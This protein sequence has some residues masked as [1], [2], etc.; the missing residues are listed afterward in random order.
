MRRIADYRIRQLTNQSTNKPSSMTTSTIP[1]TESPFAL[2]PSSLATVETLSYAVILAAAL[3]VRML[4]LGALPLTPD[5]AGAAWFAWL[6]ATMHTAPDVSPPVSALLYTLHRLTF[7]LFDGGDAAARLFPALAGAGM[8]ALPWWLRGRMGRVPALLAALLLAVDPW[9]ITASRHADSTILSLGLGLL[10]LVGLAR[11]A[12]GADWPPLM[13]VA[14]GLFLIS[15]PGTWAF[16]PLLLLFGAL[17]LFRKGVDLSPLWDRQRLVVLAASALLGG[18][19]WLLHPSGLAAVGDSLG[20]WLGHFSDQGYPLAWAGLRLVRDQV[21]LLILGLA[22]LVLLLRDA[23][24]TWG[25]FLAGWLIWALILLFLPGRTPADLPLLSLPLLLAAPR[26]LA[27]PW[28]TEWTPADRQEGLL[29]GGILIAILVTGLFWIIQYA[30]T[31]DTGV[32]LNA[33]LSGVLALFLIGFF[34][35]WANWPLAGRVTVLLST[36]LLLMAGVA[37]GWQVSVR[38]DPPGYLGY[39]R[40]VPD[41]DT[42]QLAEDIRTLSAQRAGD[43]WSIPVQVQVDAAPDP[44]LG[45]Y[46]RNVRDLRWVNAPQVTQ[47]FDRS[48]LV[49]TP[50]DSVSPLPEGYIGSDYRIRQS[51]LPSDLPDARA[52]LR[53]FLY[54]QPPADRNGESVV[55]WTSLMR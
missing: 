46:L 24:R 38:T 26:L 2:R 52:R 45:W 7:A 55:L 40:T 12:D 32:G 31:G 47:A 36:G 18:T 15:G 22:G 16:L 50:T 42:R 48:P 11:L 37:T 49:I 54:Q 25:I 19:V 13:A 21:W 41:L 3:A 35:W 29:M 10:L 27:W 6:D 5:E 51:W 34:G 30:S 4:A 17:F 44:L 23:D 39:V 33:L 53:W 14:A 43:Q 1:T 28:T 9:L 20:V 8:V